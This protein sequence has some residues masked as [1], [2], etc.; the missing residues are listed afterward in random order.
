[1]TRYNSIN[2]KISNLQV[3]K[4]KSAKNRAG[5]TLRLLI[6]RTESS[7]TDFAHEL[8]LKHKLQKLCKVLA[9]NLPAEVKWSKTKI[10]TL[11]IGLHY[12]VSNI[13]ANPKSAKSALIP[14]GLAAATSAAN[15]GGHKKML[16]VWEK[17]HW[18]LQMKKIM[19]KKWK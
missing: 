3:E 5:V 10:S 7:E 18:Q 16:L 8:L 17:K 6:K 2:I 9:D 11:L 12:G 13:L 4:R 19:E 14:L 15:S 1:M